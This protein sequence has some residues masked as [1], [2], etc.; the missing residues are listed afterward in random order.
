MKKVLLL[1]C[2]A[3]SFFS[4]LS[5]VNILWQS[6][7]T[8]GGTGNI[9]EQT[10]DFVC[11][12]SGNVYVCG[13][14][15]GT[16][17]TF[18]YVIVKYNSSGAQQWVKYYDG[19]GASYDDC[20][21]IAVDNSGNVYVTGMSDVGAGNYDIV[22]VKY[23]AAGTLQWAKNYNGTA[24]TSDE[25]NDVFVDGSGNVYIAGAS[26]G[27]SSATTPADFMTI[28]YDASGNV[29]WSKRYNYTSQI[30]QAKKV[31]VDASGN[32]YVTGQ[33]QSTSYGFDIYTIKYNSAGTQVWANRY[34]NTSMV[35]DD[36]A[37]DMAVNTA[38]EVFITGNSLV[39]GSIDFDCL[40]FKI[41]SGGTGQSWVKTVAGTL[42][43]LD[44]GNAIALDPAGD[45]LVTGEVNNGVASAQDMFTVKYTNDATGTQVW[46]KL[47]N[48][49]ANNWDEGFGIAAD[50]NGDV[51][52]SGF[53]YTAGQNN[54]YTTIK[55][56][57]A[58]GLMDWMTKYNGTGNAADNA[59]G[60][61]LDANF[62]VIVSGTSKGLGTNDDLETIK[63]CQ[64]KSNAGNDTSICLGASVTLTGSAPGASTYLWKDEQGN[65]IGGSAS[66]TVSPA[67]TTLY[68]VSI[69]NAT[70]C[71][72]VDTV[73]VLVTPLPGPVISVSPSNTVCAG[74]T[75]T[76]S[77]TPFAAYLWS[78]GASTQ[79]TKVTVSGTYTL[80]VSGTTS[81]CQS[82]STVSVTVHALPPVYA[83]HDTSTCGTNP[84]VLCVT[85]AGTGGTYSWTDGPLTTISDTAIACP[86]IVLT[87]GSLNYIVSG[88]DA[89]GCVNYDTV[90]VTVHS[91]PPIPTV[92]VGISLTANS[93]VPVAAYQWYNYNCNTSVSTIINGAVSQIYTPTATG[94]YIVTITDTN[95]CTSTSAPA[96]FDIGIQENSL[97]PVFE[98]FPNPADKNL[99]L[100]ISSGLNEKCTLKISDVAGRIVFTEQF[101]IAAGTSQYKKTVDIS[102]L[103][104]GIYYLELSGS[105]GSTSAKK[106]IK[107]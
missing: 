30:D 88:T 5:Q 35:G 12:A 27:T 93:T 4:G 38:G 63:Y 105:K 29:T 85:G 59:V 41:P 57:G 32:V 16:G 20:R 39:S 68:I 97:V 75:I 73:L 67:D 84:I 89:N 50:A 19:T 58:T 47:Y 8:S 25:G 69:T 90:K 6:R 61:F 74:D 1:F 87:G 81:A 48:G 54:N 34:N 99:A 70:G 40:T 92:T 37:K 17:G 10:K 42:G 52:V 66:V 96:T 2:T 22:T 95:G 83:G 76:L 106:L 14:G 104:P 15:K 103:S 86:T 51:Y 33:V 60:V 72:D 56:L 28:K 64:L 100:N 53:S 46:K 80:T 43:D 77:S 45:V 21:A 24:N 13:T 9:I 18:D 98:L 82:Q 101:S 91:I 7:Y 107:E 31:Y 44:R 79:S 55:Y 62:N 3:F 65:T 102:S 94:C 71:T 78:N 11:D 36:V 26:D 49:P 23:N